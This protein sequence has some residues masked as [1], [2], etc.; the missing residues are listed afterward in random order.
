MNLR[1]G[2]QLTERV[3]EQSHKRLVQRLSTLR[4]REIQAVKDGLGDDVIQLLKES[5][6]CSLI[7]SVIFDERERHIV[8]RNSVEQ[9]LL[10][11]LELRLRIA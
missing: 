9:E 3:C 10:V 2:E 5:L 11:L 1:S 8:G 4:I 6:L 7:K